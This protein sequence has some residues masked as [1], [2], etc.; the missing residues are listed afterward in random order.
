MDNSK[1]E[2]MVILKP[3][4]NEEERTLFSNELM[5]KIKEFKGEMG[6]TELLG[7]KRLAYMISKFDEGYYNVYYFALP[8]GDI[9]KVNDYLKFNE[10]T[11]RYLVT[12]K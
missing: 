8:K 4:L 10:Q 7:K 12:K 3:I 5:A 6:N 1:Y 11:L 2:L 9:K